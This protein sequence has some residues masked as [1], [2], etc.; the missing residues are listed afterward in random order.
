LDNNSSEYNNVYMYLLK[1]IR[2]KEGVF[3]DGGNV[4]S[5]Y[6]VLL[7][8]ESIGEEA[9]KSM[10]P[11]ERVEQARIFN[12]AHKMKEYEGDDADAYF[13]ANGYSSEE[14]ERAIGIWLAV[15]Y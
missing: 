15:E 13:E 5:A 4:D 3:E 11:D 2:E 14:I 7:Y 1:S 9:F 6:D 12:L 10:S 8:R